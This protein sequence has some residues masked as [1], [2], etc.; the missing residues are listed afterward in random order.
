MGSWRVERFAKKPLSE[1]NDV[2]GA[3]VLGVELAELV[4]IPGPYA[5]SSLLNK[6]LT[7]C[8]K[9]TTEI[10]LTEFIDSQPEEIRKQ[11]EKTYCKE[12]DIRNLPILSAVK[13]SLTVDEKKHGCLR[14]KRS[15]KLTPIMRHMS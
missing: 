12:A 2:E 11:I 14:I 9:E 5:A 4:D 8:K 13:A 1:I 3:L 6:M 15:G 10:S 7:K